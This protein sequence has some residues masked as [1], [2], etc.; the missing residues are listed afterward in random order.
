MSGDIG[1]EFDFYLDQ[2]V[3]DNLTLTLVAAYL[4]AGDAFCPLPAFVPGSGAAAGMFGNLTNQFN[5]AKYT[6]PAATDAWKAGARLQWN[7]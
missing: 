6:T 1:S 3:V 4:F 2:R 7:F 5:A